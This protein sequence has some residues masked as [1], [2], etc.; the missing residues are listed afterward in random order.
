[1]VSRRTNTETVAEVA[2]D[3][4]GVMVWYWGGICRKKKGKKATKVEE[5]KCKCRLVRVGKGDVCRRERAGC[6]AAL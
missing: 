5:R 6:K 2:A 4:F 3:G 1:M